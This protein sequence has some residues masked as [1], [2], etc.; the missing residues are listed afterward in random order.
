MSRDEPSSA[1]ELTDAIAEAIQAAE[2]LAL[3][4]VARGDYSQSALISEHLTPQLM[5]A[6]LYTEIAMTSAPEIRTGIAEATAAAAELSDLD[7][8]YAPLLSM[9]R[10]LREAAT[11]HFG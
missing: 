5:Q 10:R 1:A 8:R 6:K 3:A 9:L 7:P 11:R 4:S 2:E